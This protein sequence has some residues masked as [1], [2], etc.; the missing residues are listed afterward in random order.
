MEII[1]HNKE[2]EFLDLVLS[3]LKPASN[4]LSR[5][6]EANKQ[7]LKE[8][9]NYLSKLKR[10]AIIDDKQF[11]ELIIMACANFIENEVEVRISKSINDRIMFFFEKL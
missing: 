7:S 3:S 4:S 1:K 9:I 11:S 5:I 8:L 2:D 6:S 10:D